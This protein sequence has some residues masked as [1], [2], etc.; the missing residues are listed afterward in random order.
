MAVVTV[1]TCDKIQVAE[2]VSV[3][4]FQSVT[5]ITN[6]AETAV[7]N[8]TL[9]VTDQVQVSE[10]A[11]NS[12]WYLA[13]QDRVTVSEAVSASSDGQAVASDKAACS[14]SA[15]PV[16]YGAASDQVT[17]SE[18]TSLSVTQTVT[19]LVS[20]TATVQ[21]VATDSHTALVT[22]RIGVHESVA[23]TL[24]AGVTDHIA[25]VQNT[26]WQT[27]G[28]AVDAVSAAEQVLTYTV[29]AAVDTVGVAE[30]VSASVISTVQ[31]VGDRIGA[32]DQA[33]AG[34]NE[35][36]AFAS[37]E[38]VVDEAAF[39]TSG[40]GILASALQT[41]D[42]SFSFAH[43]T[44]TLR[45]IAWAL[46]GKVGTTGGVHQVD[47]GDL[48]PNRLGLGRIVPDSNRRAALEALWLREGATPNTT[49]Y[50]GAY[51]RTPRRRGGEAR[52]N[53]GKGSSR[54]R[55]DLELRDFE[56]VHEV[57]VRLA[58]SRRRY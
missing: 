31:R 44:H 27:H 13:V 57:E 36:T 5:S 51:T 23:Q 38:V 4:T 52:F 50:D 42:G 10:T 30:A 41:S 3:D 1:S 21:E 16:Y 37:D 45:P 43:S 58:V 49:V 19:V 14:E 7:A 12:Y 11:D 8:V 32:R 56:T 6:A 33:T 53:F 17:A 47:A 9:N 29:A 35:S 2:A 28:Y 22:D 26:G 25:S 40:A 46:R 48:L 34:P 24:T 15:V 55:W 18:Q 39:V 54:H 20:D